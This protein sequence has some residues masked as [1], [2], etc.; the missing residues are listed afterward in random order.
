MRHY[1]ISQD[2]SGAWYAHMVGFSWIPVFG[3]FGTKRNATETA[4]AWMALT[5]DQYAEYKRKYPKR[6]TI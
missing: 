3:S 2:K 4:A 5:A 6:F 1:T